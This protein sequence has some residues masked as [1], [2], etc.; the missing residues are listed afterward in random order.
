MQQ[1]L[2]PVCVCLSSCSTKQTVRGDAF[3]DTFQAHRHSVVYDTADRDTLVTIEV[4]VR[5]I[6]A[7]IVTH[8]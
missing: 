4:S 2:A 1:G 3:H 5:K 7:R 6:V 8:R